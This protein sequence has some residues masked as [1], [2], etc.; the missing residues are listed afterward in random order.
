MEYDV[1]GTVEVVVTVTV[2]AENGEEAIE[3]A[4]K[5]FGGIQSYCGNGGIDKLIGVSGSNESIEL[6]GNVEFDD[7]T[8][9]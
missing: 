3:K 9:H 1:H 5:C 6:D 2:E 7:W 4:Q 8:E